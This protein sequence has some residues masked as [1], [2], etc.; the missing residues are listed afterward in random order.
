MLMVHPVQSFKLLGPHQVVPRSEL[1]ALLRI[2]GT[3]NTPTRVLS[4]CQMVVD[5]FEKLTAGETLKGL[6]HQDLWKELQQLL[7]Q[8]PKGR[9]DVKK[10]K[11]HTTQACVAKLH[12][13]T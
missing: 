6:D 7:A 13:E 11:A 3:E 12:G 8:H 5:G 9:F 10:V 1:R 4:D 2:V